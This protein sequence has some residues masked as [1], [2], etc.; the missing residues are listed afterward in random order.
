MGKAKK[1]RERRLPGVPLWVENLLRIPPFLCDKALSFLEY[2]ACKAVGQ[3]VL[4]TLLAFVLPPVFLRRRWRA[5]LFGRK[6]GVRNLFRPRVGS[7]DAKEPGK[8]S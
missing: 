8:G 7:K 2:R 1:T 5:A 4:C 6:K 3:M